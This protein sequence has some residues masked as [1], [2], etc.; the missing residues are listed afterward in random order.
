MFSVIIADDEKRICALLEKSI[1]W[2]ELGLELIGTASSGDELL[3]EVAVKNPNIV[4]TDIQMPGTNG[5]DAI[6]TIREG[7]NNCKIV[8]ISG[9][10]EFAYAHNALK[11]NV[12]DYLLKPIDAEDLNESLR[13]ITLELSA[14]SSNRASEHS[15]S[16]VE[17]SREH[18]ISVLLPLL[19]K[20]GYESLDAVNF[21]YGT[22]F[23][24]GVFQGMYLYIDTVREGPDIGS[25]NS[26]MGKLRD[27]CG[28]M[29][30]DICSDVLYAE[31]GN[32]LLI[33]INYTPRADITH[34][35]QQMFDKICPVIHLF[36]G[37]GLTIG[38][39]ETVS[40]LSLLN[41]SLEHAQ[42]I[43]RYRSAIGHNRLIFWDAIKAR[44]DTVKSVKE[45]DDSI[46]PVERAIE[47]CSPDAFEKAYNSFL[48]DFTEQQALINLLFIEKVCDAFSGFIESGFA[49]YEK[50]A[51]I[52]GQL[53]FE[54]MHC[55][56]I[57]SLVE[58]V[59]SIIM[60]ELGELKKY[61]MDKENLPIRQAKEYIYKNYCRPIRLEDIASAVYLSPAYLS[62][63]FKKATGENIVN[64]INEYRV[65][66]A[67]KL[68]ISTNMTVEEV[69]TAVGF[70]SHRYFGNVFK[71]TMGIKPSEYRKLYQ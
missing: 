57:P 5:I 54:F 44:L 9:Y 8:I 58:A 32:G 51:F 6:R 21:G 68:L 70:D 42:E 18:F 64:F 19:A 10:Q 3:K 4:I 55:A 15:A 24:D 12:N 39:G 29:L 47:A 1:R 36:A 27:I 38:I 31:L 63:V 61:L 52:K 16:T 59:R 41:R 71:K 14:E 45:L 69:A 56:D 22:K 30:G 49:H 25:L 35:L 34:L 43:I 26:L 13:N 65:Q 40:E 62:N 28:K 33:G 7:N 17:D 66:Q 2:S 48:S 60:T 67:K 53:E 20:R 37:F 50:A 11:Y 23:T 46:V